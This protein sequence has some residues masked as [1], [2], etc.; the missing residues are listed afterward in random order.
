MVTKSLSLISL[1]SVLLVCAV[2]GFI[3]IS[4]PLNPIKRFI[5]TRLF[6]KP[7]PSDAVYKNVIFDLNGVLFEIS[8]NK[9]LSHLGFLDT[10]NYIFSG[11]KPDDLQ[12]K[13]FD[14]LCSMRQENPE[15]LALKASGDILV[16]MHKDRVLP[17]IFCDWMKG[18]ISTEEITK[19][20]HNK[21]DTLSDDYYSSKLEKRLI[22]KIAGMMFD[23]A[24]RCKL[25]KP[26]TKNI[27][28]LK[29]CKKLGLKTYLL[30]NM[31]TQLIE[32][33][34]AK[35]PEIFGL[36]DGIVISADVKMM[37]PHTNIYA[38]ALNEFGLNP[39]ESCFI[40]DEQMNVAGAQQSGI[41]AIQ[42]DGEKPK[43]TRKQLVAIGVLPTQTRNDK[44]HA[45]TV[46]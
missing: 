25:Y 18:I 6:G 40:D 9:A 2:V 32:L 7:V 16:P 20:T 12:N 19:Q 26:I 28:L 15:K 24:L 44:K 11:K 10:I 14:I 21:L 31:D 27:K 38:H 4:S 39:Y 43:E 17:K 34:Q 35:H 13:M 30:S 22:R 33:L 36:F 42:F 46:L 37:K 29:K 41:T 1:V 8:K 3:A 45:V 5:T 23:P